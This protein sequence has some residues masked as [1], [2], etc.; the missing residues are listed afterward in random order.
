MAV[1]SHIMRLGRWFV[2]VALLACQMASAQAPEL[3]RF[4]GRVLDS[5][6]GLPLEGTHQLHL[7]FYA[8]A[9]DDIS[10]SVFPSIQSVEFSNGFFTVKIATDSGLTEVFRAYSSVFLGI[11]IDDDDELSPRVQ[12]TSAP[13][14]LLAGDVLG[15]I[16]PD[17]VA[18]GGRTVID[19]TGQWVGDTAG[20]AGPEGPQGPAGPAGEAGTAGA[21][22]PEGP[23][24]QPGAQGPQGPAGPRGSAGP[25]GAAGAPGPAGPPGPPGVAGPPGAAGA[26]GPIGP[27]G[28]QGPAGADATNNLDAI[29]AICELSALAGVVPAAGVGCPITVE[30]TAPAQGASPTNFILVGFTGTNTAVP[31]NPLTY[32]FSYS[33]NGGLTFAAATDFGGGS[34]FGNPTVVPTP[35]GAQTWE[36]DSSADIR[37]DEEDVVFRVR[38]IDNA[39]GDSFSDDIVWNIPNQATC[40]IDAPAQ[41]STLVGN[42]LIS[43]STVQPSPNGLDLSFEYSTDGGASFFPATDA[44]GGSRTGNPVLGDPPGADTWEWAVSTDLPGGGQTDVIFRLTVSDAVFGGGVSRCQRSFDIGV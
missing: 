36:W 34:V 26:Q 9:E 25:Q 2:L 23:V 11:Q 13:Y 3:L 35:S 32:E 10:A 41:R 30:M 27:A 7:R 33:T 8:G 4:S 39:T 21:P 12:V 24:G 31:G 42:S 1:D 44:G 28:P 38:A 37:S 22:G 18:I 14:A 19:E 16:N 20:L 15:E 6:S 40:S 5:A 29:A 43:F 17:S